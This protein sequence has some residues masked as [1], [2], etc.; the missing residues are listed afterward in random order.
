MDGSV[1]RNDV[2]GSESGMAKGV[3]DVI[4]SITHNRWMKKEI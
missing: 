1:S 4:R 3:S 2:D